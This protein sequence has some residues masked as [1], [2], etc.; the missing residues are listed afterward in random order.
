MISTIIFDMDGV[1]IDSEPVH[2]EIETSVMSELG[3]SISE[4]EYHAFV[5]RTAK[6]MWSELIERF[7]LSITLDEVIR[8][9]RDHYHY[10]LFHTDQPHCIDGTVALIKGLHEAG[11]K[12][13]LASSS[14]LENIRIVM[15][16]HQLTHFFDQIVGGDDVT[17]GKPDPEIF[18][19]ASKRA[20]TLPS[21]CLVIEDSRNGVAAAKAAGMR[22]IGFNNP[23]SPGQLLYDADLVVTNMSELTALN[24]FDQLDKAKSSS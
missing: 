10:R 23:S 13:V 15:D 2:Y 24:I 18:I 22:C 7:G 3:I 4:K 19:L 9:S 20:K 1:I 17:N 12:L 11:K 14:T 5:G 16:K 8:K 21:R 6:S